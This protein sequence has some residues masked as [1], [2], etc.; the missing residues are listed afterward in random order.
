MRKADLVANRIDI[1]RPIEASALI[2]PPADERW[3]DFVRHHPAALPFHLPS[4]SL[5]LGESYGFRPFVLAVA[6]EEG[7]ITGGMPVMEIRGRINGSRWVSL[8]FTDRCPPLASDQATA[9]RLVRLAEQARKLANIQR[10]EVHGD[11]PGTEVVHRRLP[12]IGHVLPL[13][14]DPSVTFRGFSRSQVQRNVLKAERS[15]LTVRRATTREDLTDL[16]Y[17]LHLRTR[18]R[19][20]VPV[21]PRRFF[22][23]LWRRIIA[24]GGGFVL[25]ASRDGHPIAGAVF[26]TAGRT[27]IYKYGA[28][29]PSAWPLRP[30]NLIFWHAIRWSCENGF[31]EFDFGL[32]DVG[33]RGLRNFKNGWG[34]IEESLVYATLGAEPPRSLQAGA[35][36]LSPLIRR[37]PLWLCRVVGETAYRYAA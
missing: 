14:P 18:R 8:P 10:L 29:E 12:G 9:A 3:A 35:L 7:G 17:G 16:F 27:V 4:W 25:L 19:L 36:L 37:T 31:A 20:G 33:N 24:S 1:D 34:A 28:S 30:N 6:D 2:L 13:S 11:L 23:L 5:V 15:G 32:S 22:D 21:Q 26:L